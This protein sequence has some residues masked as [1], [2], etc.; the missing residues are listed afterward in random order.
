MYNI[1]KMETI[2]N[3]SLGARVEKKKMHPQKF[4]LYV[5]MGSM[6]MAF[7]GIG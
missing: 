3:A 1:L 2:S 7:A 6:S 4:L 5:A